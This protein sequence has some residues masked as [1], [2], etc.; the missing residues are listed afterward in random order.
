M[1]S[2]GMQWHNAPSWLLTWQCTNSFLW[3]CWDSSLIYAVNNCHLG[4]CFVIMSRAFRGTFHLQY[5]TSFR[6][7]REVE[8]RAPAEETSGRLIQRLWFA[9]FSFKLETCLAFLLSPSLLFFS[10]D[11]LMTKRYL[12]FLTTTPIQVDTPCEDGLVFLEEHPLN[13][14]KDYLLPNGGDISEDE[15]NSYE[16]G[17]G[18]RLCMNC[19]F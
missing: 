5:R 8:Q 9:P 14:E 12:S 15:E 10:L 13:E 2:M 19:I 1:Y 11:F 17:G 4:I 18:R 3:R 7:Q 16:Q 6:L